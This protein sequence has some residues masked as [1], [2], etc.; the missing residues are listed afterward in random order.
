MW[1]GFSCYE[2]CNSNKITYVWFFNRFLL[3][4]DTPLC[5][6]K[7]IYLIFF[8]IERK[9]FLKQFEI[10]ISSLSPFT[11]RT[12]HHNFNCIILSCLFFLISILFL[13]VKKRSVS[14]SIIQLN[15]LLIIT[16]ILTSWFN[17]ILKL[18]RCLNQNT[19]PNINRCSC[20]LVWIRIN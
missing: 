18:F 11:I 17:V 20:V 3:S 7:I 4:Q 19:S 2:R 6:T 8:R 15:T 10:W 5:L 14:T 1:S 12:I 13:F 9:T 16:S